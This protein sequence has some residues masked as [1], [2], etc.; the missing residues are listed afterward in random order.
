M[1]DTVLAGLRVVDLTQNVAG[2]YCTQV[3]GDLG[4]DVVK[5]ERPGRGDDTRDWRPPEAGG[6]SATFLAL[7][8]NKSSVC[9]DLDSP[10]GIA[11]LRRLVAASDVI[12]H[13]MKPGSAE[14]RGLGYED[15]KPHNPK[16]IYCAI[17]AFGG[18]GPLGNLPGYDPLM[19]AFT[20]IMSTTGHEGADP[21]RVGVSL[22][23]MGTG[24]WMALGV[25]AAVIERGRTGEGCTVEA[26]LLETGVTWMTILAASYLADGQIPKKLGSAVSMTAP[27]QVFRSSDGHVFIAAGN[28][29][30]FRRVCVALGAPALAEDPRFQSNPLRNA[31][32]GALHEALEAHTLPRTT[33]DLVALL[34]AAGAP[35]SEL[36]DVAQMLAH[37]QV[38]AV[39]I[40]RPL[41]VDGVPDHRVI[42][43]PLKADGA[44]S[45]AMR[46]PPRL[47]AD[48]EPILRSLGIRADEIDRLRAHGAI[49]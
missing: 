28:D 45:A 32:R 47:G 21:V 24:M 33:A 23:D 43:L 49:G 14:S 20:G 41:P 29:G 8:R 16:L 18:V 19:Q 48:T 1:L 3:L 37:E 44:R 6:Q 17:S 31:N 12:V 5:V 36:H 10:D 2:P 4:A 35:C 39:D 11:V 40:V 42:A 7:N 38:R 26:S 34:R 30:L 25:L 46:A 27:Y 13:S 15:L 9:I 22:I